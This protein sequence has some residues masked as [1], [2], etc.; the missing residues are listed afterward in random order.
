MKHFALLLLFALP[1]CDLVPDNQPAAR[2]D[3][4][5]VAGPSPSP[6]P[7]PTAAAQSACEAVRFEGARLTH[8]IAD[9]ASHTITTALAPDGRMPYRSF[10]S[11]RAE[12]GADGVAFAMNGGM[13]DDAGQPIGY[14]VED[15]ER[16]KELNRAEGPGN[17]HLKPNGVFF[18]TGAQWQVL[19]AERFYSEVKDRPA[20]GT[21]SGPM[22]VVD[23]KIHPEITENGPSRLARNGVGVDDDG[24]AHFVITDDPVSF[25][26]LA[27]YFLN[28][29]DTPNALFLDGTVS[30][31]WDPAANRTDGI[32][33][34]GPLIVVQNKATAAP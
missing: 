20:F 2:I 26:L 9:P 4:E 7:T 25:G 10:A 12:N 22:L 30:A 6:T 15:G 27:R 3:L 24:R 5:Q 1:A 32:A 31:L 19:S 14:Y 11:Y 33:P 34:L 8:C 21:Q 28:E 18:G 29:L 13:F 23:G 17:F 16:L